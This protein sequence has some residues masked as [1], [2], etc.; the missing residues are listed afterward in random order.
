MLVLKIIFLPFKLIISV[1]QHSGIKLQ[2][3]LLRGKVFLWD[4]FN[5]GEVNK[6]GVL[7]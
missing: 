4:L 1:E 5:L 6:E 7:I 2:L 3:N